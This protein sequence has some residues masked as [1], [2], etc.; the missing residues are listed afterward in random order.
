MKIRALWC[1]W[2]LWLA[3]SVHASNLVVNGNF[4]SPVPSSGTGGGW[5]ADTQDGLW[6]TDVGNPLPSFWLNGFGEAGV[7]PSISQ[8][9]GGLNVGQ[10]YLLTGDYITGSHNDL[11]SGATDSFYVMLDGN[12]VYVAAPTAGAILGDENA[13]W[14]SFSI[15]FTATA[16]STTL[17]L[18]GEANGSDNDFLVDNISIV[19]V[20]EPASLV[21]GALGVATL[22][23]IG[24]R[25]RSRP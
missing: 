14:S 17:L 6:R 25:G 16:T 9:V 22:L 18:A 20:P 19:S 10:Q 15:P 24:R 23:V 12:P 8:V 4:D 11:P 21:L 5:D 13:A 7:D 3:T 2:A 1:C